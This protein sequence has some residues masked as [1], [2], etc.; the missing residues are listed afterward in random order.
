MGSI[1][2]SGECRRTSSRVVWAG[3]WAAEAR[4]TRIMTAKESGTAHS[5]GWVSA[6]SAQVPVRDPLIVNTTADP[7]VTRPVTSPVAAP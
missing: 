7:V 1:V 3:T 6:T 2:G 5:A 4:L